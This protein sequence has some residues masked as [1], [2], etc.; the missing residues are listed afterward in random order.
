V[1]CDHWGVGGGAS[2]G[3]TWLRMSWD[4]VTGTQRWTLRE[5]EEINLTVQGLYQTTLLK[6]RHQPLQLGP[7]PEGGKA[8]TQVQKAAGVGV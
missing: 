6:P 5:G 2:G 1:S 3:K 4:Q 7:T 8:V